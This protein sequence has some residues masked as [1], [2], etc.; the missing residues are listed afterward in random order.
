MIKA[1]VFDIDNTLYSYDD[2]HAAAW[3]ALTAYARKALDLSPEAFEALHKRGAGILEQRAGGK[4][5]AIHNRLIRYQLMLEDAGLPI[6]HAP[7]MAR[8]YWDTLLSAV[9]PAPGVY[10]AVDRLRERGLIIG[11]GTNM[12]AD[13]QFE[14]LERLALIDRVDFLVTSE[15]V[16]A[17]KPA[18]RLFDFCVKKA[19]CAPGECAFVGDHLQGDALGAR[20]AG[21]AAVWLCPDGYRDAVPEGIRRIRSLLELPDLIASM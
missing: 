14:K 6:R 15:E 19:G 12:T 4:V 13:Y 20:A 5:A 21:L 8:I 10:E 2:A 18:R 1:V 16:G 11:L 9:R 17:E 7:T 3:Q